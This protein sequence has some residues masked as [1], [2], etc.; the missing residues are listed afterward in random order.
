MIKELVDYPILIGPASEL[1]EYL[2][3]NINF[4][5]RFRLPLF[6]TEAIFI[7]FDDVENDNPVCFIVSSDFYHNGFCEEIPLYLIELINKVWNEFYE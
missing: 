7:T 5:G 4:A 1:S 3:S 6:S 2:K